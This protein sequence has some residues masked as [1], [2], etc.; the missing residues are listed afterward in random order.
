MPSGRPLCK[1]TKPILDLYQSGLKVRQI[2]KEL[3]LTSVKVSNTLCNHRRRE[4][5][6]INKKQYC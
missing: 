5:Q 4:Y 2:A 6:K 3:E 1:Y